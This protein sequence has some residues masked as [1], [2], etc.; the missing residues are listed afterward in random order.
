MRQLIY[1]AL[2]LALFFA[3]TFLIIKMTGILSVE[4]IKLFLTEAHEVAPVYV[5]LAV[6][7]LLVADLFIAVPTLTV[8]IL[9]GFFLGFPWVFSPRQ[10]AF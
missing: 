9:P 8:T 7:L 2:G 10:R 6:I 1:L 3:S 5:A 4:D